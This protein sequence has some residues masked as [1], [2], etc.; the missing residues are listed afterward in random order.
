MDFLKPKNGI[1]YLEDFAVL[2]TETS[3]TCI[4]GEEVGWITSIQWIFDGKYK[5]YRKPSD[6]CKFLNSLKSKYD[7][8]DNNMMVVYIHN[9]SYD[10]EYLYQWLND[11]VGESWLNVKQLYTQAHKP[12]FIRFNGFEFRCS[13]RLSGRSLDKWSKD[14]N[15]EHKKAVGTYD[16]DKVIYQ[17]TELSDTELNY[18]KL[19]VI[20]LRECIIKELEINNNDLRS[21]PYTMTGYVRADTKS[22]YKPKDNKL[23]RKYNS[24]FKK[25]KLNVS[26]YKGISEAK[27]GGLTHGNRHLKGKLITVPAG[28]KGKHV[29]LIS[30]YPSTNMID[31]DYPIG[32][33]WTFHLNDKKYIK[34]LQKDYCLLIRVVL[35]DVC[36][37][38]DN[39][40]LPLLQS[41][42][43]CIGKKK[44]FDYIEDNGR[45]LATKGQCEVVLTDIMWD[46]ISE[47]YDFKCYIKEIYCSKK[48]KLPEYIREVTKKYFYAKTYYKSEHKR[49]EKLYGINDYRTQEAA[50]NLLLSKQRLNSIFGMT[51]EDVV[52]NSVEFDA[53]LNEFIPDMRHLDDAKIEEDIEKHY[54]SKARFNEMQFGA[55]TTEH[56]KKQIY[57]AVKLI[58]YDHFIY[59]DTDSI[60]YIE[61]DTNRGIFEQINKDIRAKAIKEEAYITIDNERTY[62]GGWDEEENFIEFKFLH[63]KC[64]ALTTE[65]GEFCCTIAGV[66]KTNGKAPTDP[67][68]IIREAELC[69]CESMDDYNKLDSYIDG[70]NNLKENFNFT[71]CGGTNALYIQEDKRVEL[72]NGHITELGN[73]CIIR[74]NTK[75]LHETNDYIIK[76]FL[77]G[78]EDGKRQK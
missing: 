51:Y 20:V 12:I 34:E 57:E 24:E 32:P 35:L 19:D 25:R 52:H 45:I 47:Q 71:K 48:G 2:D 76:E 3:H 77:R 15:T 42:K 49:L 26:Y 66:P 74:E 7:L 65:A 21:V 29:D 46:I 58:G 64:Y 50:L 33:W 61:D 55:W 6:F 44:G 23:R 53:Y 78:L 60:M 14:L 75:T 8:N 69:G 63:S 10:M 40:T 41:Y 43:C 72:I 4:N 62:F 9:M 31:T 54:S 28:A 38:D 30:A 27:N 56:V 18:D 16:Y 13:Y 70:F 39:I 73:A 36:L 67:N 17:D 22:F 11:I 37:K 68:Y 59:C 1:R 5:L